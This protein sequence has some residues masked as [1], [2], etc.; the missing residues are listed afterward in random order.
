MKKE[1]LIAAHHLYSL[2][3]S[4]EAHSTLNFTLTYNA[5]LIYTLAKMK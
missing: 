2:A 3:S 5:V 4:F 1:L